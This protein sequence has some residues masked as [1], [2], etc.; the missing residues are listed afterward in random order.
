MTEVTGSNDID[1]YQD[2]HL[3]VNFQT[4]AVLLDGQTLILTR[5]EFDL[6]AFLVRRAGELVS[7]TVL[8]TVVWEYKAEIRT[9]TIDVHIR[10]LRQS[11]GCYGK[12]YIKTILGKGY[13]FQPC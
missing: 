6:L 8:L 3:L 1:R 5:K 2:C 11:L 12:H 7:R 10:H 9:R 4:K 13:R